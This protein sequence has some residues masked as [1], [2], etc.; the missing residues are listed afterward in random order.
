MKIFRYFKLKKEIKKMKEFVVILKREIDSFEVI[1]TYGALLERNELK[2][3]LD[4][5]NRKLNELEKEQEELWK[6]KQRKNR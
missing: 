5:A 6:K 3:L 1:E 2:C 4:E